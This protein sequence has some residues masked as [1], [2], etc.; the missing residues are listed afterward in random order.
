M[1]AP[2]AMKPSDL[3]YSAARADADERI[4]RGE[5]QEQCSTLQT[6]VLEARTRRRLRLNGAL[7]YD[8][9]A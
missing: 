1:P 8:E 3:S 9:Q 4:E 5:R 2:D 6:M 7:G